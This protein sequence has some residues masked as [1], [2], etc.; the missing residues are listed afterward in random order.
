[1]KSIKIPF[2]IRKAL[3]RRRFSVVIL[4]WMIILSIL[5]I[6]LIGYMWTSE[7]ITQANNDAH[8]L[9]NEYIE[10]QK[11]LIKTQ[12]DA[13]IQ[14]IDFELDMIVKYNLK[15]S[16]NTAIEF[17]AKLRQEI[18]TRFSKIKFGP[19]GYIFVNTLDGK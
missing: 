13:Q 6:C 9:K 8:K 4:T 19:E 11:A 18:L 17:D 10:I 14:D 3:M 16:K 15:S 2:L 7:R 5:P 12:I 1:M